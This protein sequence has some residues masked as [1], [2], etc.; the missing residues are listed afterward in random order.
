MKK[1]IPTQVHKEKKFEE[2]LESVLLGGGYIKGDP[3]N[4]DPYLGLD[5]TELFAFLKATQPKEWAKLEKSYGGE[6]EAKVAKYLR[7]EINRKGTIEV[8]RHGITDRGAKLTLAFM[9]PSSGLN[10]EVIKLYKQDRITITRQLPCTVGTNE[11]VDTCIL[12]NGIPVVTI[13]LKTPLTSQTVV[14][15]VAQYKARDQKSTVFGF[16]T[17][18]LVHFAVDPDDVFM[19]TK[20]S[21]KG[22][23]F[24]PFN[25]GNNGGAGNPENPKGYKTAYLWEEV[26]Q[27]DSL[28]DILAK[29][30]QSSTE[31]KRLPDGKKIKV[32]KLLFPRYH[33]LDCV[34]AC[35]K[36]SQKEGAGKSYLIQHSAGSGKTNSIAWLAHRLSNLHDKN[37]K[38]VFDSIVVVTDRVVLDD[39]LQEAI[40]QFDHKHGVVEAIKTGDGSKSGK[41]AEALVSGKKIIIVT[42]QSFGFV[43]EQIG[44]MP[45]RK[46]AVIV[47]EAHSSQSGES[48]TKMRKA[49]GAK[50]EEEE[51]AREAEEQAKQD[52]L[53]EAKDDETEAEVLK[54]L[55]S[56]KKQPNMSFF[57]FT[58]T[59]KAKT[60]EFFGTKGKGGKPRPFH[61]YSMRQAI[62]EE[63]ILDV[64]KNYVTYETYWKIASAKSSDP[65]V[66][67]KKASRA[68][69]RFVQLHPYN[70]AQKVEIILDH[71]LRFTA[72]KIG[73]RGKAMV[74]T[75]S[76]KAAVRYKEAFDKLL[77]KKAI[78]GVKALV[79][80]SGEVEDG[81]KQFTEASMNGFGGRQIPEKFETD[82]YQVLLVADKFQTGF[83]Q[84]YLH[85]LFVD[86]RLD[87][88]QAVQTLSRVNRTCPLKEDTFILD[89]VNE[90]EDIKKA[91]APY[92]Q[93]TEIAEETDPNVLYR[94][95]DQ[96]MAKGVVMDEQ[97]NAVAKIAF[98]PAGKAGAND[99]GLIN[100]H[101]DPA[102]TRFKAL[103]KS[104]QREF[105]GDLQSF[106]RTY[107]FLSQLID[108]EDTELEKLYAYG[109]YLLR[110]LPKTP[111]KGVTLDDE[112][113]MTFYKNKK[114]FEGSLSLDGKTS[115]PIK[116]IGDATKKGGDSVIVRLSTIID[117]LNQKFGANLTP[118]DQLLF[119]Q[120]EGDM[121]KDEDL[122]TQAM[123]NDL[124]NFSYPAKEKISGAFLERT[125]KNQS[126]F[127]RYLADEDFRNTVEL[128]MAQSLYDKIRSDGE[129]KATG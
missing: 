47:D 127:S 120:I 92:Y 17:G 65:E 79:A 12:V 116:G 64:L 69:I 84:P 102:V 19:T 42:I 121:A 103:D 43:L 60:L 45:D 88:V 99:H 105:V 113:R 119:D 39:Q 46:Y 21:G 110:K 33:Q 124:A 108:F 122:R 13:E 44:K 118:E 26:L 36:D 10:A 109:R 123:N 115:V 86:K 32:E 128:I 111:G 61:L 129:L 80:F 117:V 25:K 107:A 81:G 27:K 90:A 114:T 18:A 58:A 37:D 77:R 75:S 83:D 52:K 28:M 57:A 53:E 71:Y 125:E 100:S 67:K 16:K 50:T 68:A 1:A 22:T 55:R 49:L 93:E 87:G 30:V 106:L 95:K 38:V 2:E 40:A 56:R 48:A 72:N 34:R 8:L 104:E 101:I 98:K 112:V 51:L 91:F 76:R 4:F 41:L 7:S 74:V 3:K 73:G 59:P 31:T 66:E 63:F 78:K 35:A 70:I 14:N 96:V 82:E 126:L 11:T 29:F 62:E 89:F 15:A 23:S 5:T 24:L 94:L 6:V 9:P 20:L 54:V 85:T 97:V